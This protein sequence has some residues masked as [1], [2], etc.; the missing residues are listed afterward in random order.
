MLPATNPNK[1]DPFLSEY[2]L[3]VWPKIQIRNGLLLAT[4]VTTHVIENL[5]LAEDPSAAQ[6]R[7]SDLC[8]KARGI[9]NSATLQTQTPIA[10]VTN[11]RIVVF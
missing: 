7:L 4:A 8:A 2:L 9:S 5:K 3:F 1:S 6:S 10:K 11:L